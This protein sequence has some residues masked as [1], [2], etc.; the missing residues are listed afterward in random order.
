MLAL[1]GLTI[2][3]SPMRSTRFPKAVLKTSILTPRRMTLVG[4]LC[5]HYPISAG[6]NLMIQLRRVMPSRLQVES[7]NLC[8]PWS[9]QIKGSGVLLRG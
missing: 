8:A 1:K 2:S 7:N 3:L 4:S 9:M 6:F 5:M